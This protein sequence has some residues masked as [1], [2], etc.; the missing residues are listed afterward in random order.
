MKYTPW[1]PPTKKP[2]RPGVYQIKA[3]AD[4]WFRRW[5]GLTWYYGAETPAKAAQRSEPYPT[6]ADESWRGILK[7]EA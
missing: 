1:F 2:V 4:A 6:F 7:E 5:D 3:Y